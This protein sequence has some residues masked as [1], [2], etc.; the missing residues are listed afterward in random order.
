MAAFGLSHAA[1]LIGLGV[2]A[3]DVA[4]W[5]AVAG[6]NYLATHSGAAA[7]VAGTA[8]VASVADDAA[9]TY[10]A[11]TGTPQERADAYTLYQMSAGV[12]AD[13]VVPIADLVTFAAIVNPFK[14]GGRAAQRIDSLSKLPTCISGVDRL[15]RDL[16]N[17]NWTARRGLSFQADRALA[18]AKQHQLVSIR[19]RMIFP[20]GAGE[21]DLV[22]IGNRIV[23]T[24]SWGGWSRLNETARQGAIDS[25]SDKVDRYLSAP[26]Y[27]MIVEFKGSLPKTAEDRLVQLEQSYP[28][29]LTWKVVP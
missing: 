16:V 8:L 9:L 11:V 21:P 19:P 2:I 5:A 17:P 1:L 25:L 29:R 12:G 13:G 15:I 27:T 24:K 22:L 3:W 18:Y 20:G 4:P 10:T 14:L 26:T 23:E 7:T 28:G 6:Q